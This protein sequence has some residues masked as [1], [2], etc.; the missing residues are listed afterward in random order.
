MQNYLARKAFHQ[1]CAAGVTSLVVILDFASS[2]VGSVGF[3]GEEILFFFIF[4]KV[5]IVLLGRYSKMISRMQRKN[6]IAT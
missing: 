2:A 4:Q 1:R 3:L 5:P 6:V